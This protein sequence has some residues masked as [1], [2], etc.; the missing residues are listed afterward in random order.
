M[1]KKQ[2]VNFF[3]NNYPL[4]IIL[5][6]SLII[7]LPLMRLNA[8]SGHDASFHFFRTYGTKLAILD[9]Q[10]IPMV[11]YVMLNGL[12]FAP[13]I[14]YGVLSSYGVALI[15]FFTP[16][17]G[18][19]I[20]IFIIL[21][22]FLSGLFMY[23]FMLY[24]TDNKNIALVGAFIYMI[25]PYHLYDIYYRMA[26]GEIISFVF[27]PL[28]FHGL[29]NVIYR[30]TSKWWYITIATALLFLSHTI[31][32]LMA[33]IFAGLYVLLNIKKVWQKDKVKKLI[34]SVLL[35]LLLSLP[36][37]IPLIEARMSASY[38]VFNHSF[39]KTNPSYMH[40]SAINLFTKITEIPHFI[41][42]TYGIILLLILVYIIYLKFTK[43]EKQS[44]LTYLILGIISL[45][46]TLNIFP[47][48]IL[49][50]VFSTFQFPWRFLFMTSFF[51]AIIIPI[52]THKIFKKSYFLIIP[53]VIF[54]LLSIK[55]LNAG[56]KKNILDNNIINNNAITLKNNKIVK[57]TGSASSEYL[58]DNSIYN[59]EYLKDY[60]EP[61]IIKGNGLIQDYEKTGT[62]LTSNVQLLEKSTIELPFIYYPGYKIMVNNKKANYFE[63]TN[64]LIGINLDKGTY[65]IKMHY[66]GTPLM[67]MAYSTSLTSWLILTTY[68]I[69]K[70]N[71]KSL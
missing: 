69:I 4:M 56:F 50:Q 61:M 17:F 37:F 49:P 27:V 45:I 53:I 3:K 65:D 54:S 15:S 21:T 38:M 31:S 2:I 35:A 30:D 26:F 71:K 22:I 10:L 57:S 20:N 39:M 25:I 11:N 70:K 46:L 19:A 58:T 60:K 41:A 7:G 5:I 55:F 66:Q 52:Y 36:S 13:N 40:K 63:T 59:Y 68:L 44:N 24:Y 6:S 32:T 67:I 8:I 29:Y 48:Q 64:G 47:W 33:G 12:G 28:L 9:K 62:H 42:I 43:K 14:F 23:Q 51:L 34:F 16:T 18:L 1:H